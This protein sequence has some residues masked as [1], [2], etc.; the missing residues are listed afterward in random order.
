MV[1]LVQMTEEE[2][3]NFLARDI[4]EYAEE[5]VKAGY[6][7]ETEAMEK[8]RQDHE[9]LLPD[10]LATKDHYLFTIESDNGE[11]VGMLWLRVDLASPVPSGFIFDLYVDEAFRRKGYAKQA[12]L[13][14]EKRARELGLKRLALHVFAHN[15]GAK[16]LYNQLNYKIGSLNMTKDLSSDHE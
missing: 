4:K 5:N 2:F 6:W 14:L 15:T 12:M 9:R 7:A 8:S 13:E 1:Q 10:G 16:A 11:R 3:Q